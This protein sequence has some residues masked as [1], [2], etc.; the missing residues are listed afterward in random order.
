MSAQLTAPAA[1]VLAAGQGTRMRSR[2][3][4]VLHP[5]AGRP[6]L[7]HV[8]DA[9]SQAGVSRTVV[10][11]GH[12]A[13][14]VEAAIAD[15]AATAR[16]DPQR[17][18]ADAVRIGLQAAPADAGELIVTMGDVPLQPSEL[19]GALLEALRTR[20]AA[21]ALVAATLED[22]T[23]YGRIVRGA[24]GGA[25]AIVEE[26]DADEPTRTIG[27]INVGTYAFDA[28]WL[29]EAIGRVEA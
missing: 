25:S 24:G 7:D 18:T 14:A 8:L 16:Q 17:G 29:R 1:I 5:L 26:A 23:G 22:P 21:I 15:R 28:G 11:T 3:P 13:D 20:S 4:K 27:E 12:G 10:V 9:L 2:I 6:M 19:Y